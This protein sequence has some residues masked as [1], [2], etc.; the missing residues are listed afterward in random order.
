MPVALEGGSSGGAPTRNKQG[1]QE[2]IKRRQQ[3]G[4]QHVGR[5]QRNAPSHVNQFAA[6]KASF[7]AGQQ[8]ATSKAA[9][10]SNFQ[11]RLE[12]YKESGNKAG[13]KRLEQRREKYQ[14]AAKR[15][16]GKDSPIHG[17]PKAT[18]RHKPTS[19]M[20]KWKK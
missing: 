11:N 20:P 15:R 18:P 10:H 9:R 4:P 5:I 7:L 12:F 6:K 8:K 1:R 19:P 14:A 3:N 13:V 17:H 16:L 2:A